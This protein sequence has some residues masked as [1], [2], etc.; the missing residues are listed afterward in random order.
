MMVDILTLISLYGFNY[1]TKNALLTIEDQ[2]AEL[3]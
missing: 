3:F 2:A 1:R